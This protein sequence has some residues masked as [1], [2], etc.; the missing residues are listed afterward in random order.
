L[1][2]AWR[3]DHNH[4]DLSGSGTPFVIPLGSK[5]A[6]L[7]MAQ[8]M[9]FDAAQPDRVRPVKDSSLAKDGAGKDD[10]SLPVYVGALPPEG[11]APWDWDRTW[12]AR[13]SKGLPTS[14]VKEKEKS[15]K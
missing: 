10:P 11:V 3:C 8:I 7:Q 5:D 12:R 6:K 14:D 13:V 9:G 1:F 2:E 4:R 15:D